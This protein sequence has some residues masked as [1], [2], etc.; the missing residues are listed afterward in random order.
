VL[1]IEVVLVMEDGDEL[2]GALGGGALGV[3][4]VG[5]YGDRLEINLLLRHDGDLLTCVPQGGNG[6]WRLRGR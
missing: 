1:D 3:A 4:A 2:V 6:N 5:G